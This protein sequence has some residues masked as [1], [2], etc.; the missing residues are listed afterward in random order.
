MP[1]PGENLQTWC[2]GGILAYLSYFCFLLLKF[3]K[4]QYPCPRLVAELF[5]EG[6]QQLNS[7]SKAL[8][9]KVIA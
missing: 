8:E 1:W 9:K 4:A 6:V 3:A 7:L 5:V 2:P